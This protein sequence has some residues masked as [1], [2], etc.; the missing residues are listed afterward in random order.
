MKAEIAGFVNETLQIIALEDYSAQIFLMESGD[1]KLDWQVAVDML[2]RCVRSELV[3]LHPYGEGLANLSREA[4]FKQMSKSD[5][6]TGSVESWDIAKVWVGTYVIGTVKCVELLAS[7]GLLNQEAALMLAKGL[8]QHA[9]TSPGAYPDRNFETAEDAI[10][11]AH[12]LE[13][14]I[15]ISSRRASSGL[16]VQERNCRLSRELEQIFESYG[17]PVT[18]VALFPVCSA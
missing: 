3:S 5:P 9:I 15:E 1:A 6:S 11:R 17:V 14:C 8:R 13:E 18:D 7:H 10:A 4:Y 12:V 16:A 2:Y